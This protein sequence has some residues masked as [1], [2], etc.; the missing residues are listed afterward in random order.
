MR[1]WG[2]MALLKLTNYFLSADFDGKRVLVTVDPA[3]QQNDV[4]HFRLR[5]II[6]CW[7]KEVGLI[8]MAWPGHDRMRN[9]GS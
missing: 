7:N 6:T 5:L 2:T 9:R 1:E 4:R 8:E 3:D